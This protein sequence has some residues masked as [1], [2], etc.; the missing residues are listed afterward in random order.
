MY[1]KENWNLS[2]L[3]VFLAGGVIKMKTYTWNSSVALLSPPC[4]VFVSTRRLKQKELWPPNGHSWVTL[5][6]GCQ[7]SSSMKGCLP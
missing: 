1:V 2:L 4:F 7:M 5:S 6:P 3:S